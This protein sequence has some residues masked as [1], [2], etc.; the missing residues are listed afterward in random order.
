MT[1]NENANEAATEPAIEWTDPI[2]GITFSSD[3]KDDRHNK[4]YYRELEICVDLQ[5][6]ALERDLPHSCGEFPVPKITWEFDK[7]DPKPKTSFRGLD[8]WQKEWVLGLSYYF[9]ADKPSEI[10]S[11]E[12]AILDL[13][14]KVFAAHEHIKV[15]MSTSEEQGDYAVG[16]GIKMLVRVTVER[17]IAQQK[18][19]R[20][21]VDIRN[22][23]TQLGNWIAKEADEEARKMVRFKQ[24]LAA[25]V[26]ELEEE[27]KIQL[28]T[29][30]E[31]DGKLDKGVVSHN[32]KA[33]QG[34]ENRVEFDPRAVALTRKMADQFM[35]NPNPSGFPFARGDRERI[36]L[37]EVSLE[38]I[39]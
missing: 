15:A 37:S 32:V 27:Q 5:G 11:E 1:E 4:Q 2:R 25:L 36:K 14:H 23:T 13:D 22:Q 6:D 3:T 9:P 26:T 30:L 18:E 20:E 21:I 35:P 28:A 10:I 16:D 19:I 38:K 33:E 29:M 39:E 24:R 12:E 8:Q 17:V 31:K 7:L 34:E